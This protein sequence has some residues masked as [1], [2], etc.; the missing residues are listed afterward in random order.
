ME[1]EETPL[2]VNESSDDTSP[3]IEEETEESESRGEKNPF[4]FVISKIRV[5]A[6]CILLVFCVQFVVYPGVMFNCPVSFITS[7]NW[8]IWFTVTFVSFCDLSGR[9]TASFVF[10][11]N[12][13]LLLLLV[14]I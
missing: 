4:L 6:F 12:R 3:N 14:L 1:S 13:K 11:S 7:F 2:I 5:E 8:Q 10:I 9:L